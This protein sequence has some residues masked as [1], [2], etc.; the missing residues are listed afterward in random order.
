MAVTP[1]G[2]TISQGAVEAGPVVLFAKW[3]LSDPSHAPRPCSVVRPASGGA[4]REPAGPGPSSC[5]RRRRG[6]RNPLVDLGLGACY[7][8]LLF[9]GVGRRRSHATPLDNGCGA[10][11]QV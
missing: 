7:Q 1:G 6:F 9:F 11:I 8:P 5:S 4:V 2:G 10:G 3:L